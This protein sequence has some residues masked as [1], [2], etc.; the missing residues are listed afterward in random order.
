MI[1]I[2][3]AIFYL[4]LCSVSVGVAQDA[5]FVWAGSVLHCMPEADCEAFLKSAYLLLKPG[6]CLYGMTAGKHEA[7]DWT[8]STDGSL[9][10]ML[11]SP[12]W[13]DNTI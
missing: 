8:Y 4:I 9:K 10:G 13:P 7:T 6:G 1:T 12:V 5:D 11:Y 3:L 2:I